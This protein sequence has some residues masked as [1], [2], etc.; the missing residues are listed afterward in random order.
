MTIFWCFL[1]YLTSNKFDSGLEYLPYEQ[2]LTPHCCSV[3]DDKSWQP[4]APST[5]ALQILLTLHSNAEK[6]RRQFQINFL[7]VKDLLLVFRNLENKSI[8]IILPPL[9]STLDSWIFDIGTRN[10]VYWFEMDTLINSQMHISWGRKK[11]GTK[12]WR[13]E[14]PQ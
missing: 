11:V 13:C 4:L 2:C 6:I 9:L 12:Q 14:K 1:K 10:L 8:Q 3:T 7:P 5:P